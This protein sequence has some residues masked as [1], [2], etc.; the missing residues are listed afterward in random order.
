MGPKKGK[1][2]DKKDEA[3]EEESEYA[4]MDL[5]MLKELVPMLRQQVEKNVMDRNYVQL[6][7]VLLL[8]LY[9]NLLY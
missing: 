2:K 6:E 5:E 7:R 1:G 4:I 3:P 8:S 9:Y